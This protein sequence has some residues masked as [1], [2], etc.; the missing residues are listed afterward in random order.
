MIKFNEDTE[1]VRDI[2]K[3]IHDNGGY[4]P[5][6]LQ[7]NQ[8]TK[9]MCKEFRDMVSMGYLGPCHCGLYVATKEKKS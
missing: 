4:C 1:L 3:Q 2:R 7:R 9:C 8:N 5:C 6:A